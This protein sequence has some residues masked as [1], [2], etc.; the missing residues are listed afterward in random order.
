M[1]SLKADAYIHMRLHICSHRVKLATGP[2]EIGL[3]FDKSHPPMN[4]QLVTQTGE[5][6]ALAVAYMAVFSWLWKL[7]MLVESVI[8]LKQINLL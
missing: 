7:A 8:R 1:S 6:K 3:N 2:T 5:S 4:G